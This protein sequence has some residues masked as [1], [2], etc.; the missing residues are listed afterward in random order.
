[1]SDDAAAH[2]VLVAI[3]T[4]G[5]RDLRPA[6]DELARQAA[7]ADA[8]VEVV[9]LDNSVTEDTAI[10]TVAAEYGYSVHR[11]IRPGLAQVRNAAIELLRP[12]HRALIFMD[13]DERP[14][15]SWLKAMLG[16]HSR[17]AATVVIG[18]VWIEVPEASPAW[19]G[20]GEFWRSRM[21]LPDGRYEGETYSGNTLIDADFLRR[22]GLRFD[23]R[24]DQ[25]GGEDT[26]FF[27]RLRAVGGVV[28]W[29]QDAAA[30]ERVDEVRLTVRGV[31]HRSFHAANLSWRL[32]R[33]DL[34]RSN[35]AWSLVR[36]TGRLP[37]GAG[38]LVHGLLQHR[39]DRMVQGLCD[40]A[41]AAGTW[42][43]AL[44]LRTRYYR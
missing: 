5:R 43:S 40:C 25:T 15:A 12:S 44:G 21:D 37:R 1:M 27:R 4:R 42:T 33:P 9:V 2:T 28:V 10:G 36:R 32:D 34:T 41:A 11:V 14:E 18:P 38:R 7:G 26:D 22:T 24:F 8:L 23:E 3:P 35:Q 16:A 29:A 31:M 30:I 17:Q 19:L 39:T 6:L 13:D 20:G